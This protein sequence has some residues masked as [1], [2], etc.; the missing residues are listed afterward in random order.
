MRRAVCPIPGHTQLIRPANQIDDACYA[1][2]GSPLLGGTIFTLINILLVAAI[3]I[4]AMAV[5]FPVG[6]GLALL[7]GVVVN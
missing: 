4:A 6:I 1:S 7:T 5:A 2:I 3:E